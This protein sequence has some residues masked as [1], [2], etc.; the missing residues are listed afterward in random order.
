MIWITISTG[1]L[2]KQLPEEVAQKM[3]ANTANILGLGSVDRLVSI[4]HQ[5]LFGGVKAG[6]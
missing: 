5:D 1:S 6:G 2:L 4:L 3:I